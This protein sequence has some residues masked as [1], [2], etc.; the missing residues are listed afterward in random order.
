MANNS[1]GFVV[2]KA[3]DFKF[4]IKHSISSKQFYKNSNFYLDEKNCIY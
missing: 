1:N 4:I 3:I 2:F